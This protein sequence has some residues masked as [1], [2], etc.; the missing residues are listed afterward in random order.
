MEESSIER[1][2]ELYN[3][4]KTIGLTQEEKEEQ[5]NLRKNFIKAVRMNL[6]GQL[7]NIS[8]VDADGN[9]ENLSDR[10]KN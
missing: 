10:A 4:S 3:K 7:N 2:N 8:F 1:I 5:Q 6:R 9:V